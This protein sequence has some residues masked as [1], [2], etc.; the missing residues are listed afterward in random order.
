L[1][2]W[3]LDSTNRQRLF[4][5]NKN[6]NSRTNCC[7]SFDYR[8][9]FVNIWKMNSKD[10]FPKLEE[11]AEDLSRKERRK[12]REQTPEG[13]EKKRA[14]WKNWAEK[15]ALR[16]KIKNDKRNESNRKSVEHFVLKAKRTKENQRLLQARYR[17]RNREA[18]NQRLK[19]WK[20]KNK[21]ANN[22]KAAIKYKTNLSHRLVVNCRNRIYTALKTK[23]C[24]KTI[25]LLG[26]S[27][28]EL[29]LYLQSM[30]KRG[31][32]WENHGS[33]WH[34]DHIMPCASFDLSDPNQQ[35]RCFHYTNLQPL[36]ALEN[37][38]KNKT[39]PQNHQFLLL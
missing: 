23:K 1:E 7:G 33:V 24:V 19:D 6:E 11:R 18:I 35:K 8:T 30:F 17:E 5:P 25:D 22:E 32:N 4:T 10:I 36:F 28:E 39:I 15:N 21:E 3:N 31:M 12:L 9:R 27:G 34:V 13:Q 37:L 2:L 16:L 26:C 20:Q 29:K 14:Y 38:K